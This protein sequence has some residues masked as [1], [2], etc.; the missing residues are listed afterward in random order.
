MNNKE[1]MI[2]FFLFL[3]KKKPLGLDGAVGRRPFPGIEKLSHIS[4]LEDVMEVYVS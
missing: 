3:Q 4:N 2:S 1:I